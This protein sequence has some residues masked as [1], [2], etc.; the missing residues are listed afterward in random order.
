MLLEL[1]IMDLSR[2]NLIWIEHDKTLYRGL[3]E[4]HPPPDVRLLINH[5]LIFASRLVLLISYSMLL[6]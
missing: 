1:S 2:P 6:L 4:P 3:T 5:R